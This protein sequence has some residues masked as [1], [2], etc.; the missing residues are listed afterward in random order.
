MFW[1]GLLHIEKIGDKQALTQQQDPCIL[2][3]TAS[4]AIGVVTGISYHHYRSL[5]SLED[6]LG[7]RIIKSVGKIKHSS[8]R[9][10]SS[11]MLAPEP[12]TGFIDGSLVERFFDLNPENRAETIRDLAIVSSQ[13][14]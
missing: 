9:S 13:I 1:Q 5:Q 14:D 4:G 2:F 7:S 11:G 10:C 8:Y 12:S 6:K 3:G